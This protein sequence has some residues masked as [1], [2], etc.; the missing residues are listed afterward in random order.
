M[1][2]SLILVVYKNGRIAEETQKTLVIQSL[3]GKEIDC[4]MNDV[5]N[6]N[7]S[8]DNALENKGVEVN[9]YM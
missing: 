7:G 8:F 9:R 4:F 3:E 5:R 1:R 6:G 2:D